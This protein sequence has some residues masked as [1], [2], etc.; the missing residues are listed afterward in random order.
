MN[1]ELSFERSSY[2]ASS[3][4]LEVA[5]V[6]RLGVIYVRNSQNPGTL[7]AFSAEEWRAFLAGAKNNEFDV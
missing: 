3:C 5:L 6:P 2:C 1:D 4:C 7:V